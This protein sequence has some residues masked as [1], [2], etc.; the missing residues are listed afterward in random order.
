MQV[1]RLY[2]KLIRKVFPSLAIYLGVFLVLAIG[3][4]FLGSDSEQA[5][6]SQEGI[7]LTIIN[8]DGPPP[9]PTGWPSIWEGAIR[10][11][12]CR[13]IPRPCRTQFIT[14]TFPIS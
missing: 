7:K 6:F 13:T 3:F 8:R 4:T 9:L 12:S 10:W 14:A 2:F 11:S 5:A 1:F